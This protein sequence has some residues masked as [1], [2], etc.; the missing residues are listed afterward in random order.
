[1]VPTFS[2]L[3]CHRSVRDVPLLVLRS[4]GS[5]QPKYGNDFEYFRWDHWES[6]PSVRIRIRDH[7][8]YAHV[9]QGL[10][11]ENRLQ[12]TIGKAEKV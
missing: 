7:G 1:M 4:I 9:E 8:L 10:N 5:S 2:P 3:Y 11:E 12:F 6:T